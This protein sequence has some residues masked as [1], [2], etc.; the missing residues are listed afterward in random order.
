MIEKRAKLDDTFLPG[1]DEKLE[2]LLWQLNKILERTPEGN[3]RKKRASAS[4]GTS[5]EERHRTAD[6]Q[7]SE[8]Q[9]SARDRE[10]KKNPKNYYQILGVTEKASTEEIKKAYRKKMRDYHPDK[11]NASDFDWIKQEADRMTKMIQE[12]YDV[13]SDPRKRNAY[14]P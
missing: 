3:E 8:K 10:E 14:S 4:G 7:S 13:L 12:A 1:L 2:H 6:R 11:H 9:T 5:G